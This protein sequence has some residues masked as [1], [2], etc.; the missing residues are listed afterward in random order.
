[1]NVQ[2][3]KYIQNLLNTQFVIKY[4]LLFNLNK[5]Q[6]RNQSFSFQKNIFYRSMNNVLSFEH[7][8]N[9]EKYFFWKLNDWFLPN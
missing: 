8:L 4:T 7:S 2:N 3:Y 6:R 1:M 9:N 5:K